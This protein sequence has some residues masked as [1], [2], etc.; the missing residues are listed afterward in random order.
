MKH[1]L[2]E[3]RK[4]I[5]KEKLDITEFP[6]DFKPKIGEYVSYFD[7]NGKIKRIEIDYHAREK[8][9]IY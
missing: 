6:S 8:R 1:L 3:E 9:Y 4:G 5:V 2:C 7:I